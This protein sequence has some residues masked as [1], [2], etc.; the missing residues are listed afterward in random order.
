MLTV[1]KAVLY[2]S[3]YAIS[4]AMVGFY[5]GGYFDFQAIYNLPII[6]QK[7]HSDT[8]RILTIYNIGKSLRKLL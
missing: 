2:G 8:I 7:C 3:G 5:S 6:L 1:K 4:R